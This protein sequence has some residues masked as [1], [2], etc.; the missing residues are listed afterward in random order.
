MMQ[1]KKGDALETL[2][3]IRPMS[4][5]DPYALRYMALMYSGIDQEEDA[6]KLLEYAVVVHPS[7]HELNEE[8]FF[9]FMRRGMFQECQN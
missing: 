4:Q 1:G 2:S 8:L 7:N 5:K 9:S 3:E 6:T